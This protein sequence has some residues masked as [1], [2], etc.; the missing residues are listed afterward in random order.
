[1]TPVKPAGNEIADVLRDYKSVFIAIGVFSAI[2][3]V[4]MLAP[5]LYML[6]V[7]DRVLSSHNKTTLPTQ[8]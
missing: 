5:S 3:N 1:M 6:Q 8:P 2:I 7:Y 4:L